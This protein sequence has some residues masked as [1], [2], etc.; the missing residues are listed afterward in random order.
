M[1]SLLLL[2]SIT[3]QAQK[4]KALVKGVVLDENDS[5]LAGVSIVEL[6]KNSGTATSDSG[7]FA[8]T[9]PA[10][11]SLALVFSHA[12]Y[13]N[14]QRNFYLSPGEEEQI[15]IRMMQTGITISPV[16]I[17][18]NRNRKEIGQVRLNPRNALLLPGP[19]SGVEGMIKTLVG[20]NNELT[21]QY[22]VRGGNYDENLVYI[23]DIEIFRP[24]LVSSAQQEGLSLINP[25]LARTVSFQS[26]GFQARYGDKISS[27]LDIQ[28]KTPDRFKGSAYVSLMEQ[29]LHVEGASRNGKLSF[30]A[31]TRNKTNRNILSN[32][33][34][35]GSYIP[36]SS[37][38]Q[39]F[40]TAKL[41]SKTSLECLNI[42]SSSAFTFYPEFVQKTTSVFSPLF[43]SNLGLDIYFEG[44]EKDNYNTL[45]SAVTLKSRP[46]KNLGLNWTMS[47]LGDR[48]QENYDIGGA[49]LFGDRDY[50][51][52]SGTFGQIIN[53]L[54]AG[55]YQ[56]YGR[57]RLNIDVWSLS[58]RGNAERGKHIFQW[59]LQADKTL[60]ADRLFQWEYQDSAG[61]S[62]P[63]TPGP[64][65][66]FQSIRSEADLDIWKLSGYL[67][68]NYHWKNQH[69]D[70]SLQAGIRLNH[71]DL[72]GQTLWSPR[73]QWSWVPS[74]NRDLILKA[75]AGVYSQ[76]PFYREL[77]APD[78]TVLKG[79]RAQQSLQFS[80]GA[81]Y[82]LQGAQRPYRITSEFYY[83]SLRDV[84]PYDVDNVKIRYLGGNIAKAY[85]M[86]AE[87]RIF[88]QLLKDA[89]SWLSL[90]WMKTSE[91][92]DNDFYY[93]Y[94]NA[95]GEVIGPN[96]L[97]KNIADS[98]RVDVG[99]VRRPSDRRF[100]I[101]LFLQDYLATNENFKVHLNMIYG[102][103]MPYNIPNSIKYRNGLIIDSYIRVDMG[104]SF[105]LL[106]ERSRRRS[107]NPLRDFDNIWLSLEVFNLINRANT[108]SYQLIK[109]F[110]NN[111]YAIPNRLTPRLVNLK[112]VARF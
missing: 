48:E 23:N 84:I 93:L 64:L 100:T 101:G 60:I 52:N 54:A 35:Q 112:L 8:I 81:D 56:Q 21:S 17:S 12:G 44:K 77:R 65:S 97:D 72:N 33:P 92:L 75:A 50:D 87:C 24:Y 68:D 36:S 25:E 89:E 42:F 7:F 70:F 57:N 96:T 16:V 3:S 51:K 79:I 78:G 103:N 80:A 34:T 4:K 49:Y 85:A 46:R 95:A 15:S 62:L 83:K 108:I 59:G 2:L 110:A 6:G 86:G 111:S 90:A 41:N 82:V 66:L 55:Y 31:G 99:W 20:S 47:Y 29:G 102:S 53:P 39:A 63:Y 88:G 67:Q 94:K 107:H 9:I 69:G 30:I 104:F 18:D 76:P 74:G 109:D 105:L 13:R 22:S 73:F 58:H 37:D 32:Q 61:Y 19:V 11:K 28:Y 5:P 27:V 40:I 98:N 106:D 1:A 91:N 10:E 14:E 43:S 38:I 45:L 26:G 71:N